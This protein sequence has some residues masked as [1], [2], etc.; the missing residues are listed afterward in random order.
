MLEGTMFAGL[1]AFGTF[2]FWAVAIISLALLLWQ[3]YHSSGGAIVTMV[4]A[5]ILLELGGLGL[6]PLVLANPAVS[7]VAGILYVATGVVWA[8]FKWYLHV[9]ERKERAV[10]LRDSWRRSNP[11]TNF[12]EYVNDPNL[13]YWTKKEFLPPKPSESRSQIMGWMGYWPLSILLSFFP[14]LS[15]LFKHVFNIFSG[16]FR[17]ISEAQ[18]KDLLDEDKSAENTAAPRNRGIPTG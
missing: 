8:L 18:F 13:S 15:N 17:K 7:V 10:E 16:L 5:L 4:V 12:E 11:S 2:S 14:V 1:F 6:V 3:A 9:Q